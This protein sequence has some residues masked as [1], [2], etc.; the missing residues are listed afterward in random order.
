ML[1]NL[2]PASVP[3]VDTFFTDAL[4]APS[5]DF[6]SFEMATPPACGVDLKS[7]PAIKDRC[8]PPLFDLTIDTSASTTLEDV[9]TPRLRRMSLQSL[10]VDN[11]L[12]SIMDSNTFGDTPIDT[13]QTVPSKGFASISENLSFMPDGSQAN[14]GEIKTEPMTKCN[15]T[16]ASTFR[17]NEANNVGKLCE[18]LPKDHK[19][20]RGR[21]R[22]KQL[23]KMTEAQKQAENAILREKNRKAA[24]DFRARRKNKIQAL[25]DSVDYFRTL[26]ET[27]AIEITTL[28]QE[29]ASL[30]K[31]T[32][33]RR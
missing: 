32:A 30:R 20:A 22:T 21:G 29:L 31:L 16:F 14:G 13:A 4:N 2:E 7:R 1:N 10:D 11:M 19:P 12:E 26:S 18:A 9:I 24:R 23:K 15:P 3:D 8:P 33:K 27:Q 17:G 5:I 25:H 6:N 28:K